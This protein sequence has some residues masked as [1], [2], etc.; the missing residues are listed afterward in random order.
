MLF[1]FLA[2]A[3][4]AHLHERRAPAGQLLDFGHGTGLQVEQIDDEAF[5]W[6]ERGEKTLDQIARGEGLIRP[7][8]FGGGGE[9]LYDRNFFFAQVGMTEFRTLAKSVT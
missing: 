6:F 9:V 4:G 3:K 2:G 8:L 1:Q 7:Q 5:R